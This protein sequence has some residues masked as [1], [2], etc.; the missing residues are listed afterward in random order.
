MQVV[1]SQRLDA[2]EGLEE[3]FLPDVPLPGLEGEAEDEAEDEAP[4][5]GE[6]GDDDSEGGSKDDKDDDEGG[7]GGSSM[8]AMMY[9]PSSAHLLKGW[10][11]DDDGVAPAA[12]G[13]RPSGSGTQREP[14]PAGGQP[15]TSPV[16]P[17]E[18]QPAASPVRVSE[19]EARM[20]ANAD[21]PSAP[22][23]MKRTA[24]RG[25]RPAPSVSAITPPKKKK[26]WPKTSEVE[27]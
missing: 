4:D 7:G 2:A 20:K 27:A 18:G 22:G 13:S 6:L 24:G 1:S 16:L 10:S 14:E 5:D 11:Y 15:A 8:D 17:V 21:R 25:K 9:R 3:V 26:F 19:T 23:K 12:P